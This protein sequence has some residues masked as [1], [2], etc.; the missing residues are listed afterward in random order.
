MNFSFLLRGFSIDLIN[1]CADNESLTPFIGY[2]VSGPNYIYL[3]FIR[4]Y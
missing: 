2:S 4:A 3:I 1:N